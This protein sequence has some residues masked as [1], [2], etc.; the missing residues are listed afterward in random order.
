MT[1]GGGV[2]P[3]VALQPGF[4]ENGIVQ[5]RYHLQK[6]V[7][8][9]G[10]GEVWAAFDQQG[11]R[12]VALKRLS[13]P[14]QHN[15][16][17]QRRFEREVRILQGL[18]HPNIVQIYDYVAAEYFFVMELLRGQSLRERLKEQKVLP[19][20]DTLK[21]LLQVLEALTL[22]HK[23]GLVH[24]DVKPEN[25]FLCGSYVDQVKLLD[26]GIAFMGEGTSHT[27]TNFGALGTAYYMAPEQLREGGSEEIVPA[28]DLY[29]CGIMLYEMLSGQ[30]PTRGAKSLG[31]HFQRRLKAGGVAR[32]E[33]P[34]SYRKLYEAQIEELNQLHEKM[35]QDAPQDRGSV[36]ESKTALSKVAKKLEG[37]REKGRTRS[38]ASLQELA[39]QGQVRSL[40][41]RV[42]EVQEEYP[43]WADRLS[44]FEDEVKT[45]VESVASL[46]EQLQTKHAEADLEEKEKLWKEKKA[47]SSYP[48]LFDA[49]SMT[50]ELRGL[51]EKLD[52][53]LS[54]VGKLSEREGPNAALVLLEKTPLKSKA[55]SSLQTQLSQGVETLRIESRKQ[56]YGVLQ[57]L[58]RQGYLQSFGERLSEAQEEYP[59]WADRFSGLQAE[60]EKEAQRVEQLSNHLKTERAEDSL[61][62]WEQFWEQEKGRS[63]YP[64]VFDVHAMAEELHHKRKEVDTF[65]TEV[66]ELAE[67]QGPG[68][69]LV[70]LG[71][72]PLRSDGYTSLWQQL[73]K[74]QSLEQQVRQAPVSL[75]VTPKEAEEWL[76]QHEKEWQGILTPVE[77]SS[78][79]F[80]R[81]YNTWKRQVRNLQ[82]ERETCIHRFEE[83]LKEEGP[84]RS[85]EL[86]QR[87]PQELAHLQHMQEGLLQ[88]QQLLGEAEA[89]F[90]SLNLRKVSDK[91]VV[92]LWGKAEQKVLYRACRVT[93]L[94]TRWP[95]G[96][97]LCLLNSLS[98]FFSPWTPDFFLLLASGFASFLEKVGEELVE[99][100]GHKGPLPGLFYRPSTPFFWFVES[101]SSIFQRSNNPFCLRSQTL[102]R[103]LVRF[104]D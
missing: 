27:A 21:I 41:G 61:E 9:G 36:A 72:Q 44:V 28:T 5:N 35:A 7:G 57:Q 11:Q 22:A 76:L 91:K 37:V 16:N 80:R 86:L 32:H 6:L 59:E 64:G 70:C 40:P 65:L 48:G 62:V 23:Q 100:F 88:E 51:R 29:A 93:Q 3:G 79:F 18:N 45:E 1:G 4:V 26:F 98:D 58:A 71:E 10:M 84:G 52:L 73:S 43:E 47:H 25:V 90:A 24:R 83:A 31:E 68:A 38:Y 63:A 8:R 67:D 85:L 50:E 92:S 69:A 74:E 87:A 97:L 12:E 102:D 39:R 54:E 99:V 46:A 20:Q 94:C 56:C 17:L 95:D 101:V 55:Y 13:S 66:K 89:A 2:A 82:E 33:S 81:L 103:V 34:Q 42:R 77:V 30:L 49:H 19:L 53:L 60:V 104:L 75:Q 15:P 14:L 96:R 78:S